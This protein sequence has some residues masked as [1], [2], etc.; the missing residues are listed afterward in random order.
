MTVQIREIGVDALP[1]YAR[2]P[3]AFQARSVFRVDLIDGGLGGIHLREERVAP[4]IKDYDAHED[5]GPRRWPQRY[6]MRNWAIF[7][8]VQGDRGVGA[9]TVAFNTPGLKVLAGRSDVGALWDIRVHP[10]FR[11]R[12][13]GT[14]LFHQ[15]ADWLGERGCQ[16]MKVETQNI[17][18][19]ACRFYA[20]RGCQLG[21]I[22]RYGYAGHPEVRHEVML[23]WY[24]DL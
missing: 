4:Y 7:L 13:I 10:D 23:I 18:V 21:E 9:A 12:G 20:K 24:L 11:R 14:R 22:N 2:I 1:E 15:A 6:D 8:A 19:P 17:N 3:I 5:S 16:Q